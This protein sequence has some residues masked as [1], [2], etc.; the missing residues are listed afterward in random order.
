MA[1]YLSPWEQEKLF[2]TEPSFLGVWGDNIVTLESLTTLKELT[3]LNDEV[4]KIFYL[5]YIA[6]LENQSMEERDRFYESLTT[7]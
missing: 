6:W 7:L 5:T 4:M 2:K 1:L 3:W